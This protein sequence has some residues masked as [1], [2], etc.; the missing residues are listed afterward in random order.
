MKRLHPTVI[1][2]VAKEPLGS[3][4]PHKMLRCVGMAVTLPACEQ[5]R[6]YHLYATLEVE[7][8]VDVDRLRRD[9]AARSSEEHDRLGDFLGR[10]EPLQEN[11]LGGLLHRLRRMPA[12]AISE[13]ISPAATVLQRMFLVAP[14]RAITWPS[15]IRPALLAA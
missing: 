1:L 14:N 12:A 8:A 15:E 6:L 4:R 13:A 5:L 11:A 3:K 9:V 7:P 10:A 2:S